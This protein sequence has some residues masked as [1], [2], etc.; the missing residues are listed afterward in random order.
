MKKTLIILLSI[1]VLFGFAACDNETT[2]VD[3]ATLFSD[4]FS[5]E[6]D[7]SKYDV[8]TGLGANG[9]VTG[10][11][12]Y[13]L[14]DDERIDFT[15]SYEVEYT[16]ALNTENMNKAVKFNT[17]GKYSG[18]YVNAAVKFTN[19]EGTVSVAVAGDGVSDNTNVNSNLSS[20]KIN[21]DEDITVKLVIGPQAE[22][23]GMQITG[24]IT[25]GT[26]NS[27]EIGTI[28]NTTV[29]TSSDNEISW[30]I[31]YGNGAEAEDAGTILTMKNLSI[32]EAAK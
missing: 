23:D 12:A 15:K 21:P 6:V 1:A 29:G 10:G 11:G 9:V 16:F 27:I 20:F 8:T 28:T 30:T 7:S 26:G 3:D 14:L 18:T 32:A 17:S 19:S 2:T 22:A 24:S 13:V 4:N 5:G 31:Y 25:N